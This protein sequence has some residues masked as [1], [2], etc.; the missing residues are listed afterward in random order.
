[1]QGLAPGLIGPDLLDV[2]KIRDRIWLERWIT[3]PDVMLE[4]GDPLA[5]G[6]YAKYN[7]VPMPNMRMSPVDVKDVLTY[8]QKESQRVHMNR[9]R[10]RKS[11]R[12]PRV[13]RTAALAALQQ[14]TPEPQAMDH[15]QHEGHDPSPTSSSIAPHTADTVATM[16]GWI[17][18]AHPDAP[19]HAGY[20]TLINI[21]ASDV[22]LVGVESPDY[23]RVELH[24][25][26][27]DHGMMSMR[28]LNELKV[29]AGGQARLEPGGKHLMLHEPKRTLSVGE[30]VDLTLIFKSGQ[31][32]AVSVKV[33]AP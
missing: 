31:R 6:L 1:M 30:P 23:Q 29:P 26:V 27:T 21:G 8:I 33:M 9:A 16:N 18:Q 2:T 13:S 20:L 15:A 32:Q 11:N 24:E 19:T 14:K 5:L 28:R 25:M 4:E 17:K 7:E 22:I 3:E 12:S 10:T